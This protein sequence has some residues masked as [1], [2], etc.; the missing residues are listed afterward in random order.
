MDALPSDSW[1]SRIRIVLVG[2]S[3]PG[4]IGGVARAMKNMGLFDLALVSPRCAPNE[5]DAIARASGADDVL[6]NLTTHHT[7]A[8]ALTGCTWVVGCSARSRTLPWPMVTPREFAARLPGELTAG[9]EDARV[10]IVFGREDTGLT[11]DELQHC[12]THVHILTNPQFSSLNLGAAVQVMA[13]EAHQCWRDHQ[14]IRDEHSDTPFGI[15]WDHPL[16][17]Q[18][19]LE[20]LFVHMER[21]L[22]AL[23][24]HDPENPRQLMPRLRRLY[25]RARPDRMEVNILR[26][27]ASAIEKTKR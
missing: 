11:N 4:N 6:A 1:L 21:S 27:I 19:E 20:Q 24:F 3:H 8:E 2:T 9:G 15:E 17:T 14:D 16:A 26:G 25:A 13:Y 23:G 22:I 12:Q 7:L 5:R 18:D 10:A